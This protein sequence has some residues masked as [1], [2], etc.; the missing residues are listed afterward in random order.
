MSWTMRTLRLPYKNGAPT[1]G[2]GTATR[3]APWVSLLR[4]WK[5]CDYCDQRVCMS[6]CL[7][8]R[9]PQKPH[10]QTPRS[11][12]YMLSMAVA[13]TSSDDN[14][15]RCVLPVLWM[16]SSFHVTGQTEMQAVGEL[17]AVTHQVTS[18]TKSDI[19][20]TALLRVR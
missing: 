10:V 4:P 20:P 3:C 16:T 14:T 6:V 17:F 7:S 9:I 18:G 13:R 8:A 5:G 1:T 15:R 11:V 12:L 19:S 2:D